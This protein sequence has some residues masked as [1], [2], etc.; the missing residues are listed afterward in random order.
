[1]KIPSGTA[2]VAVILLCALST[3]GQQSGQTPSMTSQQV[4]GQRQEGYVCNKDKTTLPASLPASAFP[5]FNVVGSLPPGVMVRWDDGLHPDEIAF[6]RIVSKVPT[7]PDKLVLL[8]C[9]AES[10]QVEVSDLKHE[11]LGTRIGS[12]E[13]H[14]ELANVV[15]AVGTIAASADNR[16]LMVKNQLDDLKRELDDFKEAAC[17]VLRTAR[18]GDI[19]RMKLDSACGLR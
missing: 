6:S 12:L 10:L 17:P 2:I 16:G 5:D 19:T 9:M 8:A 15:D 14:D 7:V 13:K 3:G 11:A 1:M 4:A 18:M